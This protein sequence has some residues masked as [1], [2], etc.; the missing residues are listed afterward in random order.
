M[1]NR[2][3]RP[4]S[5]L[6]NLPDDLQAEI[7]E[8]TRTNSLAATSAWLLVEHKIRVDLSNVA[9]WRSWYCEQQVFRRAHDTGEHIRE[10]L[11]AE[12]PTI[13]EQE[14]NRRLDIFFKTEALRAGDSSTYLAFASQGH[15]ERMEEQRAAQKQ[16]EI[17]LDVRRIALLERAA[18]KAELAERV[19]S[20]TLAPAQKWERMKAI[21]GSFEGKAT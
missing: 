10:W 21:F 15:K 18:E 7:Y 19:M 17:D 8:Y 14:L 16:Q 20:G 6:K 1:T 12:F 3:P 9:R 4:D 5:S 2:K 13:S 11:H